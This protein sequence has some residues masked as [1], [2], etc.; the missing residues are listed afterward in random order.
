[1][2]TT[3]AGVVP[4]PFPA[5]PPDEPLTAAQWD[6]LMAVMDT[7]IPAVQRE[8]VSASL[9]SS[10]FVISNAEYTAAVNHLQTTLSNPP[11]KNELDEYLKEKPSESA[12]F[13]DLLK[14][15]LVSYT[16]EDRRKGLA[17]ILSA[18]KWVISS[19]VRTS[20]LKSLY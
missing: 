8:E 14:R 10:T 3:I 17:F 18:L 4:T 16:R 5:L 2:A 7:I 20:N 9:S 6:M 1:M 15:Q 11:T 12:E 19:T 13:K